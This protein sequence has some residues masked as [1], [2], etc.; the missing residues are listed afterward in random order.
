MNDDICL[1][2]SVYTG[3]YLL[4]SLQQEGADPSLAL[5][6]HHHLHNNDSVG[7]RIRGRQ[8]KPVKYTPRAGQSSAPPHWKYLGCATTSYSI[9]PLTPL[10]VI[11][12]VT[13]AQQLIV[14]NKT[15]KLYNMVSSFS[16]T[17]KSTKHRNFN[18][19]CWYKRGCIAHG[20]C[21]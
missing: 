16:T 18:T 19:R 17:T 20:S 1:S 6:H 10:L 13:D 4:Y 8:K 2:L 21:A 7:L 5:H 14:D 15:N 11:I 3:R 12:V 9:T